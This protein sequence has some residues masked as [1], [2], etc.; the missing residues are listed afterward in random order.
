MTKKVLLLS[1]SVV[2]ASTLAGAAWAQDEII[3]T[4]TKREQTLQEVP[5]AVSVVDDQ[6][7]EQTQI[8]DIIDLQSVVPSLY[9]SQLQQSANT[10]FFIRGFGNGSNNVGVEPSVAVFIDGVYRTRSAGAISD[11]PDLERVEVLRGPQSTL[12]GKNASA[13]VISFITAEPS[14]TPEGSLS[15][16]Y[17]NYD[18]VIVRGRVSGPISDTVAYSLSGSFNQRDGYADNLDGGDLNDRDRYA[19]RGQLLFEPTADLSVRVIGDYDKLDEVCCYTPIVSQGPLTDALVAVGATTPTEQ[20]FEYETSLNFAPTN[21]V[22]NAG[23]SV[24][25]DYNLGWG[26]I[27]SITAY[28]TQETVSDGDVDFTN[29]P[30][31]SSNAFQAD[32]KTFTQEL[33]LSGSTEKVDWL[34]GG[35]YFDEQLESDQ[36][37]VD[38][39]GF[40]TFAEIITASINAGVEDA[41]MLPPG[42]IFPGG[43]GDVEA[44]AGL[45]PFSTFIP[46]NGSYETFEQDNQS[47]SLFGQVDYYL[48]DKLTLTGGLAYTDDKKEVSIVAETREPF[49]TIDLSANPNPLLASYTPLQFL[50]N[51]I[52]F[53]NAVEDGETNDDE[54]TYTARV[55]YDVTPAINTYFSYATGFKAS[56]WNLSRDSA[57]FAADIAALGSAGLL[58]PNSRVGTRF[59]GP[60]ETEVFELGLKANLSWATIN[61]AIF[62]QSIEGFQSTIFQGAGFVLANAGEQST[63]GLEIDATVNPIDSVTLTMSGTFLDPEYDD[64]EGAAVVEGSA[65]D[66]ADGEIDGAGTLTGETPAGI[67]KVNLFFGAQ[68]DH[69]FDNGMTGFIR[70]DYRYAD[71]VQVVDNVPADV[72]SREISTFNAAAGLGWENGFNA[73]LW[74]RN[75]NNDEYLTSAFPTTVQPGSFSAYPNPPRT[76]GI[77]VE[78]TF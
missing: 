44:A 56:S 61:M 24:H 70:G 29:F 78:K 21:E 63:L 25:V 42:S 51:I 5:V 3:V 7:I 13:G 10:S 41:L 49:Y 22:E 6:L 62:D 77:T 45:A 64:F 69:L 35:F 57:P 55:A 72:A 59:A 1:A 23:G 48:T 32:I 20:P 67:H 73:R 36:Q 37:V 19:L 74:V 8:N 50:G 52:N 68:Y 11:F 33:R 34:V 76:Y 38:G 43:L 27:S 14:F 54:L 71:D 26:E 47:Y 28:R 31:L 39:A 16:T 12:F 17:G 40:R 9:V 15:L 75:L 18:Q 53:P 46:G 30:A 4:A 65:I 58:E 66:A 60:E 2:A